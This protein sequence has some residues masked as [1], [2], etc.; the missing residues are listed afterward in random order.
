MRAYCLLAAACVAALSFGV[1]ASAQ[2]SSLA[3]DA[4]A[5]GS[6]E[7]ITEATLSPDGKKVVFLAPIDG[8]G[9][10]LT[11]IDTA[12][13][14]TPHPIITANGDPDRITNCQWAASDRLFCNM[15]AVVPI[16]QGYSYVTRMIAIN[17]DGSNVK[18]VQPRTG[19]GSAL[20]TSLWGGGVIDWLPDEDGNVLMVRDHIPERS[21]GQLLRQSGDGL[22]VDKINIRTLSS[23]AVER[24]DPKAVDYI[25][26]GRGVVRII[27]RGSTTSEGYDTGIVHY[28]YRKKG[29]RE[30]VPLADYDGNKEIGFNPYH[31]DSDLDV[32]YGLEKMNGRWVAVTYKLDGSRQRAVLFQ[33][34]GGV[35]VSGFLQIGRRS[36][37][38]GVTYSTESGKVHYID[39]ALEKLAAGI[40]KALPNLPIINFVD[41]SV[42]ESILL[43]WAGSDRDPGRYYLLDRNTKKM[44]ELYPTR[45]RLSATKLAEV[46]PITY[47]AA[48]GTVVPAYLTLPPGS[49]GKN[50]PAIVMPHGGPG[51]RDEWGFDWLSQ[52]YAAR[53][54]AV[55]QPNFRGSA[56]Y[57]DQ[58]FQDNGFQSWPTAIGDVRDAGK[59]LVSAGIA[60]PQKLAIVGWSYGG[61]AAL[62]TA[63]TSPDLFHA[64]IA[65][66]PVTDLDV[67]RQQ[68]LNF[69][70]FEVASRFIGKGPHVESGSP[71]RHASA[72][73]APVLM[74]SGTRDRN[75]DVAH[76][77][78][79]ADRLKGAGRP[80]QLVQYDK[81]D[82]YLEDSAARIDMLTRSDTFLRK[83]L[84]MAN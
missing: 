36:R 67:L 16:Q 37:V 78:L 73:K 23:R 1:Q 33:A 21:T 18:M 43:L 44:G 30:W 8:Q 52:F 84:G 12:G 64:V 48:D 71:A 46:R 14:A 50:L 19:S 74:F 38:I 6:R 82:H 61:Y 51:A 22:G 54:F 35:D 26:D 62:Q 27:G 65:I 66:A 70:N 60:D 59:Y 81:L 57:G 17:T 68:Y 80:V 7:D 28:S 24:P 20:R 25:T 41:S 76:S 15:Y 77:R 2:S 63:A 31:V 83:S 13:D 9:S 10:V 45:S 53:G 34:P 55:I 58:W 56:G 47:K 49:S 32:V 75:V 69:T 42:D 3:N 29:S 4:T 11:M 5:F 79:M 39:P 72:I 40:S